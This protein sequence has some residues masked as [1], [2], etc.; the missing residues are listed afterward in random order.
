[1]KGTE[2]T[3]VSDGDR[4]TKRLRV[5]IL[6]VIAWTPMVF[7]PISTFAFIDVKLLILLLGTFLIWTS[8]PRLDRRL[9]I[10]ALVW[11]CVLLLAAIFGADV[12]QSLAG[13]EYI[14]GGLL[15][16]VPCAYLLCIGGSLPEEI[17]DRLPGWLALVALAVAS[18]Y[19][20][21]RLAPALGEELFPGTTLMSANSPLGH[22]IKLGA[23]M[24]VGIIAAT[25]WRPRLTFLPYGVVAVLTTVLLLSTKRGGWIVAAIGL[26]VVLIR[27]PARRKSP[28]L[29]VGV[30]LLSAL[31]FGLVNLAMTQQ[32]RTE[33]APPTPS[34]PVADREGPYADSDEARINAF[35]ALVDAWLDRPFLGWGS[36]NTYGAYVSNQSLDDTEQGERG[37]IDAHNL[38]LESLITSGIVGFLALVALGVIT[39][40][41]WRG[42]PG[43]L[44]WSIGI[45]L[46]LLAYHLVEPLSPSLTPLL[47]LT[48]GIGIGRRRASELARS[49][50]GGPKMRS[51]WVSGV[52]LGIGTLLALSLTISGVAG[53][54]GS[55][56]GSYPS[57][58]IAHR[59]APWRM[60]PLKQ[61]ASFF[62][63]DSRGADAGPAAAE[64]ATAIAEALVKDHPWDPSVRLFA[65]GIATLTGDAP[66]SSYW[67]REQVKYFPADAGM[68]PLFDTSSSGGPSLEPLP[69]LSDRSG[70]GSTEN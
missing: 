55:K 9:A 20:L 14:E 3:A 19:V 65:S 69:S 57:L 53:G 47:F 50:Q 59:L 45:A 12:W 8:R 63:V 13:Q 16:F 39:A 52:A 4:A 64:R 23:F 44:A 46:G 5:G 33:V 54:I 41:G 62:A 35:P 18:V 31:V 37:L 17:R 40:I 22:P 60:H 66:A 51:R 67:F 28:G 36:A 25:A 2:A 43:S 30:I 11:L 7:L 68:V 10:A 15:L 49:P 56:Y 1:M 58:S 32:G 61:Q 29:V 6:L 34:A 26:L 38:V 27:D 48:A 70:E 24:G 42:S 21:V